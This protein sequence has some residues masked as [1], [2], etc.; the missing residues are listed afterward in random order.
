MKVFISW[1]G[2]TAR[3]AALALRQW[4]P[5][6]VQGLRPWVSAS[7]IDAG[8]RWN[9]RIQHELSESRFGIIC[10]TRE[11]QSSPWILFEAGALAKTIDDTFVCPYLLDLEPQD[12]LAGPLAQFQAKRADQTGTRELLQTL[13]RAMSDN[14]LPSDQVERAFDHWWPDLNLQLTKLPSPGQTEPARS[15]EDM[16]TEILLETREIKR[17]ALQSQILRLGGVAEGKDREAL[18][19]AFTDIRRRYRVSA[20][21]YSSEEGERVEPLGS[22][23]T[24]PD[25]PT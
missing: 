25:K 9:A 3:S 24:D 1:S 15:P 13:N 20:P 6:V 8:A 11:N 14:A 16:L 22:V 10:I 19:A 7:D 23:G 18:D 17:L 12:L 21:D 4:L 2:Q 5:D